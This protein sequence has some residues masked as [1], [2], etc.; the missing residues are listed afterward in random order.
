M[1]DE[2]QPGMCPVRSSVTGAAC[3]LPEG[4]P[5]WTSVRFHKYPSERQEREAK[6]NQVAE[7]ADLRGAS[8]IDVPEALE[9]IKA[10]AQRILDKPH[11]WELHDQELARK[12][13]A[14]PERYIAGAQPII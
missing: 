10:H 12:M 9:Q 11:P 8:S 1:S 6:L 2:I 13:L 3:W 5:A 14:A 4:H 7:H